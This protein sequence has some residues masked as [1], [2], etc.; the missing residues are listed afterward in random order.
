[1]QDSETTA[2]LGILGFDLQ[3]KIGWPLVGN[4]GNET[5]Y[6]YNGDET[7]RIPY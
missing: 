4:K 3:H 2:S 1:M 6:G 5:I 7:S